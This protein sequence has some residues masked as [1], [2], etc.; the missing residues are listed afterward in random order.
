[1]T[2]NDGNILI[3]IQTLYA[4]AGVFCYDP[5]YTIT[6]S[7]LSSIANATTDGNLYYRGYSIQDLVNKSTFVEVCYIL[8]YGDR[9]SPEGLA[10]FNE[11]I[12][13]EMLLH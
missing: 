11:K 10:E 1:M 12:K 4:K 8:L 6:G 2:G 9:P 7:C 13:S 5:G 3:D